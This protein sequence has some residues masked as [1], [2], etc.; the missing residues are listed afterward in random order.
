MWRTFFL[1]VGIA[2]AIFGGEFLIVERAV[3]AEAAN[4]SDIKNVSAYMLDQ[5][6]TE[7]QT[8]TDFHPETVGTMGNALKRCRHHSLLLFGSK[9]LA[10][11]SI[12]KRG[13]NHFVNFVR[14]T[15]SP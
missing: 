9:G 12:G 5:G 7:E 11:R 1:A 14:L 8:S 15:H 4:D 3:W 10:Q 13:G 2:L 6:E